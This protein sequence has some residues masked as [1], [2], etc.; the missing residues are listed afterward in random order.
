MGSSVRCWNGWGMDY[1][2]NTTINGQVYLNI[3]KEKLPNV[4]SIQNISHF[5]QDGA[6]CHGTKAL[7]SWLKQNRIPLL[8][9]WP[10]LNVTE[11]VWTVMKQKVSCH[12]PTSEAQ[13]INWIKVVW[14]SEIT[15]E[16]C[17][18]TGPVDATADTNCP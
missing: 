11:N 9:P 15:P 2:K 18:K 17:K 12:N 5:Q 16:F 10:D 3:L 4:I 1:A 13:L 14:V 7:K 8:E 6:P